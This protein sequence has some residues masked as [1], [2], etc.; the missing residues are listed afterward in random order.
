MRSRFASSRSRRRGRS[1]SHRD[2]SVPPCCEDWRCSSKERSH[3]P[4]DAQARCMRI[5]Y[6]Y[7]GDAVY[8]PAT[9]QSVSIAVGSTNQIRL[10]RFV[11]TFQQK[12][13]EQISPSQINRW[14]TWLD[15]GVRVRW[16]PGRFVK[17][18]YFH[19]HLPPGGT[20]AARTAIAQTDARK[21]KA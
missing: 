17:W 2:M 3:T 11:E 9:T 8:P 21:L 1:I 13:S 7:S 14:L 4:S 16:F 5:A 15:L 19:T 20:I 12:L 6:Q 10:L 18:V